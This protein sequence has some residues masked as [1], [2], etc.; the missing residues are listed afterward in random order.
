MLYFP[1]LAAALTVLLFVATGCTST[2]DNAVANDPAVLALEREVVLQK[3]V[4]EQTKQEALR[5][6]ETLKA[7]ESQLAAAKHGARAEEAMK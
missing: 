7:K 3:Q 5:A 1:K 4:V 6:E 2:E